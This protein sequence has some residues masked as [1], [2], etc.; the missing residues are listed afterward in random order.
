MNEFSV[1]IMCHRAI[2]E[3]NA[4]YNVPRASTQ[5]Q[6]MIA[7]QST[8]VPRP[9]RYL[10]Q[11]T[12]YAEQL[13][14]LGRID[15]IAELVYD[16]LRTGPEVSFSAPSRALTLPEEANADYH[17][18]ITNGHFDAL[19]LSPK[20]ALVSRGSLEESSTIEEVLSAGNSDDDDLT[21][22]IDYIL[23]ALNLSE[24]SE[25]ERK[26]IKL[27]EE[28][29]GRLLLGAPPRPTGNPAKSSG[30]AQEDERKPFFR[31]SPSKRQFHFI[32]EILPSQVP[33]DTLGLSR[34]I[35]QLVDV[36]ARLSIRTMDIYHDL[37]SQTGELAILSRRLIQYSQLLVAAGDIV[38]TSMSGPLQE[39]GW[40]VVR[41][42]NEAVEMVEGLLKSVRISKT[43]RASRIALIRHGFKW[44]YVLRHRRVFSRNIPEAICGHR[45]IGC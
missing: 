25:E 33:F 39:L 37:R 12:N 45:G 35:L 10:D 31:S 13:A 19:V 7:G 5:R 4:Q 16:R 22:E 34:S 18:A 9:L 38:R 2:V 43:K 20:N 36:A 30:R 6:R 3:E 11:R 40:Q 29:S 17:S 26:H 1:L 23:N 21:T 15:E 24:L 44:D 32:K 14:G 27:N 41:E 28:S 42:S 8:L